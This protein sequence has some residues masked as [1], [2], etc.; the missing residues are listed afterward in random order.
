MLELAVPRTSDPFSKI[1]DVA[2]E[3]LLVEQRKKL[4]TDGVFGRD[5]ALP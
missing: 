1:L 5:N 2:S 4:F 3:L